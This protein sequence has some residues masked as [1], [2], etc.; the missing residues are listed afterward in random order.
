LIMKYLLDRAISE[1][2]NML[3]LLLLVSEKIRVFL[4]CCCCCHVTLVLQTNIDQKLV[5][6]LHKLLNC[7]IGGLDYHII[8][9]EYTCPLCT[10]VSPILQCI[11]PCYLF[12]S[13]RSIFV[14]NR[15]EV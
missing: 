12:R 11:G 9:T 6:S 1:N 4:K 14:Y 5:N 15:Y 10:H 2:L 13:F 8:T 7:E 3:C